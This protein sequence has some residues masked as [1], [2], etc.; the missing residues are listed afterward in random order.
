MYKKGASDE[1]PVM[2]SSTEDTRKCSEAAN[3]TLIEILSRTIARMD[4]LESAM[5]QMANTIYDIKQ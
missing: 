2:S 5:Q 4:E 1:R 3:N